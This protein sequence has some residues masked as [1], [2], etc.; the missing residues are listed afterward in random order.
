MTHSDTFIPAPST[1]KCPACGA[2][3][4]TEAEEGLSQR[5]VCRECGETWPLPRHTAKLTKRDQRRELNLS[6]PVI[7]AERQPLVTYS[8]TTDNAWAAK[9][10]GDYWPEPPRHSRLPITM[11]AVAATLFLAAFFVGREPA[12]AAL[13]D[14]AGL[15]SAIGLPV[16]LD[17]LAIEDVGAERTLTFDGERLTVRATIRNL[18]NAP[19]T[20]P[21][22]AAILYNDASA[23]D[24]S[25]GFDPPKGTIGAGQTMPI[26]I[27][28]DGVA[29]K[30][31]KV[32]LRFRRSGETLPAAGE[33][34]PAE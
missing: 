14:L 13:P 20:V 22:L 26:L 21:P 8:N 27:D 23:Q 17:K 10:A 31:T 34:H 4:A 11:A 5:M 19:L 32:A 24:G 1:I 2:R 12:V 18:G 30:A 15:Y 16:N 33:A 6:P 3:G 25:Y 7:E 9:I 29:P 28:L